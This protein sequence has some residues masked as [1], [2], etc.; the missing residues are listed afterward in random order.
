MDEM[1]MKQED[2][3]DKALLAL[4]DEIAGEDASEDD[5]DDVS[6]VIFDIAEDLAE[7]GEISEIPD[8]DDSE[9]TKNSWLEKDF[10]ILK[11]KAHEEFSE[12]QEIVPDPEDI[13]GEI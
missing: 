11:T 4:I 8:N 7:E 3:V 9:E 12:E 6:D 5:L 10:P 1:E 2:Q 13:D